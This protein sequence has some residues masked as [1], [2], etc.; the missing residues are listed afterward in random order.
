MSNLIYSRILIRAAN[1]ILLVC[2]AI[3]GVTLAQ[4]T[5]SPVVIQIQNR[6]VTLDEFN[7]RFETA[8]RMLA[9]NQ[10]IDL[11]TQPPDKIDVLRKQYLNQHASELVMLQEAERLGV[12]VDDKQLEA[13]VKEFY[14]TTGE[15][16]TPKDA[17][18]LV[19]LNDEGQLKDYLRDQERIRLATEKVKDQIIVPPGDVMTMHHDLAD[20]I[21]I[22]DKACMRQIGVA[23]EPTANKLLEKLKGGA[24]F[25]ELAKANSTDTKT[26]A[27]GGDM[28]C[29]E[30]EGSTARS[31]FENAAYNANI[32]E[33]TGP[34]KSDFGYHL[35]LVYEKIAAHSPTL[36]EVYAQLED[37][38]R[39]EKLPDVLAKIIAGSEVKT[40][41]DQL[42][43]EE[44][45]EN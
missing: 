30:R 36:N 27:N 45:A 25:A 20:Q 41:P 16:K 37:E 43:I 2:L 6:Q 34:V 26:A 22:P 17:L 28:G 8:V 13:A 3:P 29:F 42:G 32:G 24:D 44:P 12:V 14:H 33:I 40:F 15:G 7:T 4:D 39:H 9:S 35:I 1:A 21:T 19:G 11:S 10:G 5:Q 31:D 23:D 18:K 38:I